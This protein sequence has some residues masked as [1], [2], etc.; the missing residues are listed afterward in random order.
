MVGF[1]SLIGYSE[2]PKT[3]DVLSLCKSFE[4]TARSCVL[5]CFKGGKA[6]RGELGTPG[7]LGGAQATP[8]R[9]GTTV[10]Q[11]ELGAP[12]RLGDAFKTLAVYSLNQ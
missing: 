2:F 3:D 6:R 9:Q 8:K 5:Q 11:G 10:T 4:L 1:W 7:R 12:G